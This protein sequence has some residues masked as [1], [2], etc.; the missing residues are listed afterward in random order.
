MDAADAPQAGKVRQ[1]KAQIPTRLALASGKLRHPLPQWSMADRQASR[2]APGSS[3]TVTPALPLSGCP[4]GI[5]TG[6]DVLD[7][8][9][10]QHDVKFAALFAIMPGQLGIGFPLNPVG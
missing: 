5:G 4:P 1:H 7:V 3:D 8:V 2:R 9:V 10:D 6:E